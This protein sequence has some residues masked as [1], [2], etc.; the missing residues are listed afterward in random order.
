MIDLFSTDT[1]NCK[2]FFFAS[3]QARVVRAT[4]AFEG[5]VENFHMI[6]NKKCT[7]IKVHLQN[8]FCAKHKNKLS[9]HCLMSCRQ[10]ACHSPPPTRHVLGTSQSR[11]VRPLTSINTLGMWI[12]E[13]EVP[14]LNGVY[15]GAAASFSTACCLMKS[16]SMRWKWQKRNRPARSVKIH[17]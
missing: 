14:F 11:L 9:R 16:F 15:W 4:S 17:K 8:F 3:H 5:D 6:T 13:R 10:V 7:R 12:V 2:N 1:T